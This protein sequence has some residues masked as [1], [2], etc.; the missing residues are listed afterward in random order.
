MRSRL[1]LPIETV[2]VHLQLLATPFINK[3]LE[4]G[5]TLS[6]YRRATSRTLSVFWSFLPFVFFFSFLSSLLYFS[7]FPLSLSAQLPLIISSLPSLS[8]SLLLQPQ[9][10]WTTDSLLCVNLSVGQCVCVCV[11][12]YLHWE[13]F[14]LN[15]QRSL[16]AVG[17]LFQ[18]VREERR[19]LWCCDL[20]KQ[21]AGLRAVP[22]PADSR[23]GGD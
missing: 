16:G 22:P 11:C 10:G 6:R 15:L 4:L 9:Q 5:G 12:T 18:S 23:D 17:R 8:S 13:H 20:T 1:L 7:N 19:P 21:T 14:F 3:S 2:S